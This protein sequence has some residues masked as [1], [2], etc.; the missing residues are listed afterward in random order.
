MTISECR[1]SGCHRQVRGGILCPA[2]ADELRSGNREALRALLPASACMAVRSLVAE[3]AQIVTAAQVVHAILQQHPDLE[4]NLQELRNVSRKALGIARRPAQSVKDEPAADDQSETPR[5][6]DP[7]A[8]QEQQT[9]AKKV[10]C[11][12]P[13]CNRPAASRG[14]CA[15]C[16]QYVNHGADAAKRKLIEQHRLPSQ[17][18]K[19][20]GSGR[21][22]TARKPVQSVPKPAAAEPVATNGRLQ[23]VVDSLRDFIQL[24]EL[25]V[26]DMPYLDGHMFAAGNRVVIIR[27][28]GSLAKG[29]LSIQ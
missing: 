16:A 18:A 25:P 9:M 8:Q 10:T 27:A 28:D 3:G 24:L 13:G 12:V 20:A 19:G 5:A 11:A 29:T 7:P 2:C 26:G 15:G 21:G 14:I 23:G 1:V 17:T 4:E 22:R 6:D